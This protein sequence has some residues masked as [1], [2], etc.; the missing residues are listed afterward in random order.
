MA[1]IYWS[2]S[3]ESSLKSCSNF[4]VYFLYFVFIILDVQEDRVE[5][6]LKV[7]FFL[8]LLIF[9]IDYATFPDPLFSYRSEERR[10]GITIFFYGQGFTF[11]GGFYYLNKFFEEKKIINLGWFLAA[12]FCLFML[13]QA[14]MNLFA[15][16]LGFFLILIFSDLS[17]RYVLS[18]ALIIA[19]FVFYSTSSIFTG[20]K[21]ETKSQAQFYKEDVRVQA[22]TYFLTVLQGG[23]PT[24]IF[25]NGLP[26]SDSDLDIQSRRAK[27]KGYWTADVGLTGIFSYFGIVGVIVWLLFFYNAFKTKNTTH[28][29]YLKAY[30]L[31]LLTTA[32]AGYSI[33]EPGYMP[34]TV[35]ALYLIRCSTLSNYNYEDPEPI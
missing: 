16:A 5:R 6:I 30:F 13:T 35:L 1:N 17:L 9:L 27:D 10:N 14:R 28:T 33:F 12:S 24:Q 29:M 21:D 34:A 22:H 32:I 20:I 2:Q 8:S 25:G 15:L 19:G 23:L 26:G 7:L 11:L 18:F 4:Y 3:F 31:T